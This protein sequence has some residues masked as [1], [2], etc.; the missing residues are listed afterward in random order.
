VVED[1]AASAALEAAS[2][3]LYLAGLLPVVTL[4]A[5]AAAFFSPAA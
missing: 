5:F 3:E 1:D 2:E 4:L